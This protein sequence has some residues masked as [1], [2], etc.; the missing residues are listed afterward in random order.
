MIK[1]APELAQHHHEIPICMGMTGKS[2][3]FIL[4]A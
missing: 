4:T 3:R 1:Q 2:V